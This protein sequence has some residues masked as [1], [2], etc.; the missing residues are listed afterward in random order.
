MA[1]TNHPFALAAAQW[2]CSQRCPPPAGAV[3]DAMQPLRSSCEGF[4]CTGCN[5][6]SGFLWAGAV[7]VQ[8]DGAYTTSLGWDE[9]PQHEGWES[10]KP[11]GQLQPSLTARAP[12][13]AP[14]RQ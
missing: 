9:L 8:C 7:A 4:A 2:G 12:A 10:R 14:R 3:G 13:S 1:P 11:G 6:A 5:Q